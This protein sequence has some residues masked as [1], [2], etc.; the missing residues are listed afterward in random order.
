MEFRRLE[1]AEKLEKL[2]Q[3]AMKVRETNSTRK[4][5]FRNDVLHVVRTFLDKTYTNIIDFSSKNPRFE[6]PKKHRYFCRA[7]QQKC[8]S[9]LTT[10]Y[11]LM[12]PKRGHQICS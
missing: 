4:I 1:S 10:E 7:S 6:D 3:I 11:F 5:V 12:K 2:A 8:L 9:E